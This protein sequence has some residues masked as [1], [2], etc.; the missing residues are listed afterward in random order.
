[1]SNFFGNYE[2]HSPTHRCVRG[3]GPRYAMAGTGGSPRVRRSS[4]HGGGP[5][6]KR[7]QEPECPFLTPNNDPERVKNRVVVSANPFQV[8]GCP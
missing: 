1:M 7:R 4:E 6:G 5:V 8:S 2:I 3:A